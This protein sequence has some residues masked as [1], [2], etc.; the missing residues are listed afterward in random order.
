MNILLGLS[1][2]V[3]LVGLSLRFYSWFSQGIGPPESS[4]TPKRFT[5][6]IQGTLSTLLSGK[7]V[8]VIKTFFTDVLF[9]K[10]LL[11]KSIFRWIAHTLIFFGFILLLIMHGLGTGVS[12]FFFS[13]YYATLQ[14]YLSLR[15]LFGLMVLTG[16]CIALYRRLTDKP[17]RVKS[18]ASDWAS[19]A[20]IG[21]II[22]TGMMLESAK[23]SS[24]SLYQGMVEEY[25]D[26]ADEEEALALETY[27]AAENGVISPNVVVPFDAEL[28]EQG[29]EINSNS[30]IEC[31]APA[32]GAFVSF[33]LAK[34]IGPL[35]SSMGDSGG[36][37]F[38]FYLHIL[39]CLAFLAWL[40]F[41][42]MFHIIAVPISLLTNGVMGF[43]K[44]ADNPAN[45]FNRQMLGLS[46]CTHCGS[47]SE[48]CSSLMFY[49]SFQN[50]F[51]LPSEK[52]QLLKKIAAGKEL[53]QTTLNHLQKGLYICTSCDR[54]S[55]I[56]PS[57]INLRELFVSSRYHLLDRGMPE[58]SILSHFSFPLALAQSFVDDHLKALKKVEQLFKESFKK[59]SDMTTLSLAKPAEVGNNSYQSCY[60]CQRCTNICPVVRLYDDPVET[61]DMLPH[62]IIFSLGIGN[63][64]IAMGSRMIWSCS[65]C[66]LCQEHCPNQVELTDIFYN[67]KNAAISKIEPGGT[68]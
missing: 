64:E 34:V 19:L 66:Y 55:T 13:D 5:A 54:C 63:K 6:A 50:D 27:W 30:C 42:K 18:Y 1:I 26:V 44:P 45:D 49:E 25:G 58:T 52:V 10:R 14:P 22:F 31:H 65:T 33:S 51:I 59:L 38:F 15:N 41:S 20:F 4:V 68:S 21:M 39:T 7:L 24:Y 47:C 8:V 43:L 17:R 53:D 2:L 46:A 28:I 60:S 37:T 40:P 23:I 57:G 9:Q 3:C 16:V 61:L 32:G 35:S 67:L 56:C 36:V 11:D 12:D 62:Q 48:L 29:R